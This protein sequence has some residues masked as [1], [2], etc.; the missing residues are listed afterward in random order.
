MPIE[1]IADF[2]RGSPRLFAKMIL[3]NQNDGDSNAWARKSVLPTKNNYDRNLAYDPTTQKI[4]Y[5][6]AQTGKCDDG[7]IIVFGIATGDNYTDYQ[8]LFTYEY[9]IM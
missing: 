5:G 2:K 3:N 6:K 8:N 4:R 7:C 1:I 9:N